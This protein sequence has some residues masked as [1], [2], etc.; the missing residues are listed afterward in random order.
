MSNYSVTAKTTGE[1]SNFHKTL[2]K[3][4]N[5]KEMIKQFENQV[6]T[7]ASKE[8]VFLCSPKAALFGYWPRAGSVIP[9]NIMRSNWQS[10]GLAV[11]TLSSLQDCQFLSP[12]SFDKSIVNIAVNNDRIFCYTYLHH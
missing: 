10:K 9:V 6:M 7:L 1:A 12:P 4:V 5:I 2:R 8:W 3:D 11:G